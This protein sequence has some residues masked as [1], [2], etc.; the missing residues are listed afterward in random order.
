[1]ASLFTF[2]GGTEGFSG[3]PAVTTLSQSSEQAQN[4]TFSLKVVTDGTAGYQG[5]EKG[6]P[7]E[8]VPWLGSH[9]VRLRAWVKGVAGQQYNFGWDEYTAGYASYLNTK[10]K[11]VTLVGSDWEYFEF[12]GVPV[13]TAAILTIKMKVEG[14]DARTYY[15]DDVSVYADPDP[16]PPV[17]APMKA[18]R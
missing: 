3:G 5:A 2:E 4:G 18:R 12:E 11:T 10:S 13:S 9:R 7:K 16:G 1:M 15:V 14:T 17:F 6:I 8:D